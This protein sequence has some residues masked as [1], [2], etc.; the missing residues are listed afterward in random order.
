MTNDQGGKP[1]VLR[2][3]PVHWEFVIGHFRSALVE[4]FLDALGLA[5]EERRVLLRELD[6]LFQDLHR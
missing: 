1:G 2:E 4:I 5:Q 6:E 3:L